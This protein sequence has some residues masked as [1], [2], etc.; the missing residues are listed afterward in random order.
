MGKIEEVGSADALALQ[1][2]TAEK[3]RTADERVGVD[4]RNGHGEIFA[5]FCAEGDKA[6]GLCGRERAR[7]VLRAAHAVGRAADPF[8]IVRIRDEER[9]AL[10]HDRTARRGGIDRE[11]GGKHAHCN[12][13]AREGHRIARKV[14]G[15]GSALCRRLIRPSL[16]CHGDGRKGDVAVKLHRR[17]V[18]HRAEIC[19]KRLRVALSFG[20]VGHRISS[21]YG[22]DHGV[23][24]DLG[25]G[26]H[27]LADHRLGHKIRADRRA[28][29]LRQGMHL[30]DL[31]IESAVFLVELWRIDPGKGLA[32]EAQLALPVGVGHRHAA[33]KRRRAVIKRGAL[34]RAVRERKRDR[35]RRFVFPC[36]N[37]RARG[38]D[39]IAGRKVGIAARRVGE[40]CAA[41]ADVHR[42]VHEIT[43]GELRSH[44][45][46]R[47]NDRRFLVSIE[48]TVFD[49]YRARC[50]T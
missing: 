2:G 21:R 17:A 38:T 8:I 48:G 50:D 13:A 45:I 35:F 5:V 19:G 46:G 31:V 18:L 43:A 14:K 28:V 30:G 22:E 40:R 41:R 49:R 26:T 3:R 29:T 6:A 25:G 27:A 4:A 34:S 7:R 44:R 12:A 15:K 36:V 47:L 1:I 32:D 16:P 24:D 33:R 20:M 37:A 39:V 9:V 42:D 10:C 11:A 23:I